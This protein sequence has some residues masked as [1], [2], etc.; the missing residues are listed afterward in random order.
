MGNCSRREVDRRE[1]DLRNVCSSSSDVFASG[2]GSPRVW[3]TWPTASS[4]CPFIPLELSSS[5]GSSPESSCPESSSPDSS[6]PD[7]PDSSSPVSSPDS[8]E[9]SSPESLSTGPPLLGLPVA[10]FLAA[11]SSVCLVLCLLL[12]IFSKTWPSKWSPEQSKQK[13]VSGQS[14]HLKRDPGICWS[15]NEQWYNSTADALSGLSLGTSWDELSVSSGVMGPAA[16]ATLLNLLPAVLLC[17][18]LPLI[19][20][21]VVVFGWCWFSGLLLAGSAWLFFVGIVPAESTSCK[22]WLG[23]GWA[24]GAL[25]MQN[26]HRAMGQSS[27][28][29]NGSQG[30]RPHRQHAGR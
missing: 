25:I 1:T 7:S 18:P 15:Q 13:S 3:A 20:R 10:F 16:S 21:S 29:W 14:W 5:S 22:V 19:L 27:H 11:L 8:L 26:E 17:C 30:R 2:S 23:N 9:S 28:W 24:H 6:S 4:L 12:G